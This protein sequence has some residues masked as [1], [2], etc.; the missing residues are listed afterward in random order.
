MT[1]A[2]ALAALEARQE[3]KI[4]LGLGRFTAH[5]RRL[6]DPH[7]GLRFIHV[8]GTNGKGSVCAMLESV[9]RGAG[10]KTGLYISPHL[11]DVRERIG[12]SGR[13][14]PAKA[15]AALMQRA[16]KSDPK[17]EL[18]YFELL[19]SVAFQFFALSRAEAVVLETG[20][21]GRLDATNVVDP[22]VSV[23][24]SIDFDHMAFL[25]STIRKIAAEKA[26]IIKRGRP[27]VCPRLRPEAM[28]VIAAKARAL[29][30]PLR[31]VK[32]WTRVSADW[33]FNCQ[34]LKDEHGRRFDLGLLG[35]RQPANAA[36]ARAAL[37]AAAPLLAVNDAAVRRGLA[38]VSWPGRFEVRRLGSKT[39]ILDGAHNVEAM[40]ALRETLDASPWRRGRILY[41]LG[42]LKDKDVAGALRALGGSLDEVVTVRPESPRALDPV[43]LAG[44]VRARA[45]GAHV[46]VERDV[47]TALKA[48]RYSAEGAPVA[49]VCGS[50]Y[51][52]GAAR[53]ALS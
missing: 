52:V 9:L 40:T 5:L 11:R 41:I 51:L 13:P 33:R 10:Y 6:G 25:G 22:M 7:K 27:V 34:R 16:L 24:T 36:V 15:F 1:F 44:E 20:L 30:A 38:K 18:T 46:T 23:I 31:V 49:V 8:A 32:P 2:R 17:S 14:I 43:D 3:A 21:G 39:L 28:P 47:Q 42:M 29:G 48:W 35:G 4:K 19:T 37:Q 45:K 53:E 12:L 26:G 50:F